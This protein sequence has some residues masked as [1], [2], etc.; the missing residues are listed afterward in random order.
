ML[1]APHVSNGHLK[2]RSSIWSVAQPG[3]LLQDQ[4]H[5]FPELEQSLVW[6][7]RRGHSD[8]LR[9]EVARL[10]APPLQA[11]GVLRQAF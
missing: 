8:L 5:V 7:D 11:L 2:D 4:A 1:D 9:L 6:V 3:N 10:Q